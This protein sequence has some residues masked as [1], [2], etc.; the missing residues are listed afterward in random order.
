MHKSK[1][2][3]IFFEVIKSSFNAP[4]RTPLRAFALPLVECTSS[5][6][7]IYEGHIA[8]ALSFLQAPTP[9]HFSTA[10]SKPP[11]SLKSKTVSIDLSL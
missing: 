11:S 5:L 1:T 2:F 10:P 7:A 4:D 6:V 8:P 3:N 9:I